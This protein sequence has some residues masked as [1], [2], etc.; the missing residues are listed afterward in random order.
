MKLEFENV[1]LQ[2][3]F[4]WMLIVDSPDLSLFKKLRLCPS[5]ACLFVSMAKAMDDFL[6]R[7]RKKE[8]LKI[9]ITSFTLDVVPLSK[10]ASSAPKLLADLAWRRIHVNCSSFHHIM[11][12]FVEL[13]LDSVPWYGI[14]SLVLWGDKINI[15]I[16][17]LTRYGFFRL[18]CLEIRGAESAPELLSNT[19]HILSTSCSTQA[20]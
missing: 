19:V 5:S 4:Y 6:E 9:A 16:Q 18:R 14:K 12:G 10:K 20:P 8:Y 15:W 2:N 17:F 11:S 1:Q 7:T 3:K 13:L